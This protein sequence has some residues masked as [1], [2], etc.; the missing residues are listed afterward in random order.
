[1]REDQF[2][3]LKSRRI[4]VTGGAGFI[5][6]NLCEHLLKLGVM[7]SC[8]DN[9]STGHRHNLEKFIDNPNFALI[10]G[11][12]RDPE[13]C[14]KVCEDKEYILHEAALGSVPRSLK[15]PVTSN[16]VNVSGFLNMLVAAKDAGVKRFVYAA[17]SSTYGDSKD[18]PKIE[19][20]I[21]KPL[22][23]YAITKYVN[24]LYADI[25]HDAYNLDTI[26]LRYFNVFGRKQD[27]NGAYAAVIPKFVMQFMKHESPVING[28]GTYSRDFTYIDNVIQMNLLAL[29]VENPEAVNQIYNTAV[30]DRTNLVELT[31]YLK[32]FLSEYDKEIE[33][34]EVQHGPNRPG[35]IPHSLASVDKARKLLGYKPEF[36]IEKGL[37][38]AVA[39]YW[40]NLR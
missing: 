5:G 30:G 39:W 32:N 16:E 12:I 13:I 15:D 9:F 35:D 1:M 22:S 21:G 36:T 27:P 24:E 26:G 38:E 6:S 23:P 28:D 11:D 31:Q 17:S 7:V 4:L 8:L 34:I 14:K 33:K 37:K 25:F 2:S 3:M 18:L 40:H 20:K 29:T 19:D 10:E